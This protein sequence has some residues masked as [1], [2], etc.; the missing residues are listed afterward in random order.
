MSLSDLQFP[1]CILKRQQGAIKPHNYRVGSNGL[2]G[3][4]SGLQDLQAGKVRATKLVYR[5][6]ETP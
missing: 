3:V 2:Q 6:A 1:F 5:V 4:I